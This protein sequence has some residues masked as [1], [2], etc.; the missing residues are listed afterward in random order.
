M[1]PPRFFQNASSAALASSQVS[2]RPRTTS[3]PLS[4]TRPRKLSRCLLLVLDG[5][6]R[7]PVRAL[8]DLDVVGRLPTF[9]LELLPVLTLRP[10]GLEHVGV[11]DLV[12][13]RCEVDA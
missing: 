12:V 3:L 7:S 6:E 13:E 1:R 9:R 10:S 8:P 5:N 2:K 4:L 11:V